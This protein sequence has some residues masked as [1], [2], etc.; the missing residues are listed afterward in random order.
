MRLRLRGLNFIMLHRAAVVG[1]RRGWRNTDLGFNGVFWMWVGFMSGGYCN[2]ISASGHGTLTVN[3][4]GPVP[5]A[6]RGP[7]YRRMCGRSHNPV[8]CVSCSTYV[9]SC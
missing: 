5:M 8:F 9:N 4:P 2:D 7:I 1:I 3:E 6:A